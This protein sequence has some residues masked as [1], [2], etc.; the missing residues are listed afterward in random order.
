M[1]QTIT[2]EQTLVERA[3]EQLEKLVLEG[4]FRTGDRL[5]SEYEMGRTL[6][7]SRT[8]VRE[9]V[10]HLAAKGLVE[11]RTGSGIYVKELGS[12]TIQG[13]MHLLMRANTLSVKQ[14]LEVRVVVEVEIAGLAADRAMP[15]DIKAM[16]E[17]V[18]QM[19]RPRTAQK[20]SATDYAKLDMRF[21]E[22]LAEASRNPLFVALAGAI[23]EVML[24]PL[25]QTARRIGGAAI[26]HAVI[27]HTRVLERVKARDPEGARAAMRQELSTAS[28]V[29]VDSPSAAGR[30]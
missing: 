18:R 2:R 26:K 20:L 12:S 30:G 29:L 3:Q 19:S 1:L 9:A 22:H 11:P 7:V 16:E 23:R 13:P 8:V 21:H 5:P 10:R 27:D 24:E 6:G 4:S 28:D 14:I 17:T 25:T 15:E